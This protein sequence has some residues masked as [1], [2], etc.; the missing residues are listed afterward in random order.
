VLRLNIGI[1]LMRLGNWEDARV[2]LQRAA[3]P[4]GRGV[5]QGTVQYHLGTCYDKLGRFAEAAQAWRKARDSAAW[6]TEDGPPVKEL[7][8]ARLANAAAK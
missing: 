1:A 8:E 7:A 2:E 6:L 4:D 3:L 5:A